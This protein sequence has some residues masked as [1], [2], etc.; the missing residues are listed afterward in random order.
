MKLNKSKN[1][2]GDLVDD[3]EDLVMHG[4]QV[5]VSR[6]SSVKLMSRNDF[7]TKSGIIKI[8]NHTNIMSKIDL[9]T[10]VVFMD[11]IPIMDKISYHLMFWSYF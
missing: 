1:N 3:V 4:S 8:D 6:V 2:F 5:N 7:N 11:T 9:T 10:I